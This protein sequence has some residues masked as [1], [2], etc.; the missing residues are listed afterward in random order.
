[1]VCVFKRCVSA[2]CSTSRTQKRKPCLRNSSAEV[3]ECESAR[4]SDDDDGTGSRAASP[5][6][7]SFA[8]LASLSSC[9][10]TNIGEQSGS[11]VVL[12]MMLLIVKKRDGYGKL[13]IFRQ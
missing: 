8:G 6:E 11:S 7:P 9:Q 12:L 2:V 13:S 3:S 5:T 1:V 4:R 10:N